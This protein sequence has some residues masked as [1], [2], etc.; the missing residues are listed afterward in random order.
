[1]QLHNLPKIVRRKA[2]RVGRGPGSGKGKTSS[3][4]MKGQK[5][6]SKIKVGFEGGQLKYI[7]RLP[8]IRGRGGASH[9]PKPQIV[10]ISRL[11][12]FRSGSRVTPE[13]LQKKGIIKKVPAAGIKILAKGKLE[14]KV[15]LQ[16]LQLSQGAR[17]QV[18]D[19]GGKIE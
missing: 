18:E 5:A 15:T 4:G 7:K 10:D 3:R 6:R 16:G 1:M 8:F 19:K 13:S 12:I 9:K 2:K 11:N 17:K 14:K